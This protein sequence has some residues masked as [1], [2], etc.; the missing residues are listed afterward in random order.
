MAE[1]R[2]IAER[3]FRLMGKFDEFDSTLHSLHTILSHAGEEE[4]REAAKFYDF[5]EL[6]SACRHYIEMLEE[7]I[8]IIEGGGG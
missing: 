3:L 4:L 5:V 1:G 8:S 7:I 6:A 2:K